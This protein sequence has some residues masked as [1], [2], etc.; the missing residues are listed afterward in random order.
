M[1]AVI[2][3]KNKMSSL[4][5]NTGLIRKSKKMRFMKTIPLK[6]HISNLRREIIIARKDYKKGFRWVDIYSNKK[7]IGEIFRR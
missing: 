2:K 7:N 4:E 6:S 1:N 5:E 3:M